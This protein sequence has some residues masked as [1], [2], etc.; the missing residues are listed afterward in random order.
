M[1]LDTVPRGVPVKMKITGPLGYTYQD[2]N[3][4]TSVALARRASQQI[5][6]SP[7]WR[8]PDTAGKYTITIWHEYGLDQYRKDD[9]IKKTIGV[10]RWLTYANWNNPYW[11][12]WAGPE[13]AVKFT[14]SDFGQAYPFRIQRL[15]H[16]FYYHSQYP[17]PDSAFQFKI[18]ASDGQ[19]LLYESDTIKAVSYPLVIEHDVTNPPV[20]NSGDFWVSVAPRIASG[21]PSTLADNVTT[22]QKSYYG[23][24]GYWYNWGQGEFFTAVAVGGVTGIEDIPEKP[25]FEV[26]TYPNPGTVVKIRWQVRNETPVRISLYDV[27]GREVKRIYESSDR[28]ANSGILEITRDVLPSGIYIFQLK[29]PNETYNRKV[30]LY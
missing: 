8:I 26:E 18:Y 16:Q 28:R 11:L 25:I 20:I 14:P 17:W 7:G 6:F 23:V 3:E 29:T 5:T 19:T 2:L 27:T 21:H 13:R 10:A 4:T 24:P 9:T 12:T 30:V 22:R 1:G 15:R